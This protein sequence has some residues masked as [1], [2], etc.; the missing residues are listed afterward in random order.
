M[1]PLRIHSASASTKHGIL[2]SQTGEIR[3]RN[4]ST[5]YDPASYDPASTKHGILSSQT[6]EI[7][8]KLLRL[9]SGLVQRLPTLVM[10]QFQ[11]KSGFAK[12]TTSLWMLFVT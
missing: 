11:N 1:E 6:G 7:T 8:L 9:W 3:V 5:N 10:D 2:S 12:T 4:G